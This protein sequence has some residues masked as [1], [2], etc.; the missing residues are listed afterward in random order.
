MFRLFLINPDDKSFTI[1]ILRSEFEKIGIGS[2]WLLRAD[3]DGMDGTQVSFRVDTEILQDFALGLDLHSQVREYVFTLVL[4]SQYHSNLSSQG[5][6]L[7][8]CFK[9]QSGQKDV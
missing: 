6:C 8:L 2:F 7:Y 4:W 1:P 3:V 5:P 9:S